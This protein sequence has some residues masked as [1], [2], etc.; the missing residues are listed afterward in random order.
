MA[1]ALQNTKELLFFPEQITVLKKE[2]SGIFSDIQDIIR[3]R[4]PVNKHRE[5][6]LIPEILEKILGW[7]NYNSLVESQGGQY[8]KKYKSSIQDIGQK[9]ADISDRDDLDFQFKIINS[10]H[11]NAWC[12]PGGKIAIHKGLIEAIELETEGFGLGYIPFEDKIAAVLSH[13]IVHACARHTS[14]SMEFNLFLL[15]ILKVMQVAIASIFVQSDKPDENLLQLMLLKIL[16]YLSDA[17]FYLGSMHNSR[18]HELESD[19]FGMLYMKRA[20]FD[21]KAAIWLQKFLEKERPDFGNS[22]IDETFELFSS[23]PRSSERAKYNETTLEEL[24]KAEYFSVSK[25]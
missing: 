2:R 7:I 6:H 20:G 14:G 22:F 4:N 8:R 3:P 13:E 11:L 15:G 25:E 16:D 9:L 17:L 1:T 23:H 19:K 12:L 21:P 18:S 10:H 24:E 5:F